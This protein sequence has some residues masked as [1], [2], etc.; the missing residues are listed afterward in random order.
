[1][2][3]NLETPFGAFERKVARSR[4]PIYTIID[5]V[6]FNGFIYRKSLSGLLDIRSFVTEAALTT[7]RKNFL[8]CVMALSSRDQVPCVAE[9]FAAWSLQQLLSISVGFWPLQ[10]GL[11]LSD[12]QDDAC[13]GRKL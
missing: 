6:S 10:A 13:F 8:F 12:L 4:L 7:N 9:S 3:H 1:M 2:R 11:G 5:R